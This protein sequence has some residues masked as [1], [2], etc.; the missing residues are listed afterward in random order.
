MILS[1]SAPIWKD[2]I[3][4]AKLYRQTTF[5]LVGCAA[6]WRCA[7]QFQTYGLQS[8]LLA[9]RMPLILPAFS[10]PKDR[11]R[12]R[13]QELNPPSMGT[14]PRLACIMDE[15]DIPFVDDRDIGYR[16]PVEDNVRL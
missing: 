5:D 1:F 7:A 6:A 4:Y 13:T 14:N 2:E 10:R 16:F 3:H 15:R 8:V 11:R 9:G 12:G